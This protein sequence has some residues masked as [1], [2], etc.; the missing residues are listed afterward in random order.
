[1]I[2]RRCH[3]FVLWRKRRRYYRQDVT[4]SGKPPEQLGIAATRPRRKRKRADEDDDVE[5]EVEEIRDKRVK[6]GLV[7]YKVHWTDY[8]SEEDT[9]E[10]AEALQHLPVLEDFLAEQE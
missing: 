6:H 10:P 9:W 5:Y 1:M 2:Q 4:V 8:D 3:E 7:M